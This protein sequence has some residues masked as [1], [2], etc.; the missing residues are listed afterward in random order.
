MLGRS[1][2]CCVIGMHCVRRRVAMLGCMVVITLIIKKNVWVFA[3]FVVITTGVVTWS[4]IVL[5]G[6]NNGCD[7]SGYSVR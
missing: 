4:N 5:R 6:N 7:Y 3:S 1:I 2:P